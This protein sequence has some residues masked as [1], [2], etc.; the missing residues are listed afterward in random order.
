[1]EKITKYNESSLSKVSSSL[2]ADVSDIQCINVLLFDNKEIE[3]NQSV[4]EFPCLTEYMES[5]FG[6]ASDSK[7]KKLMAAATVMAKHSKAIESEK[8]SAY[9]TPISI[10]SVIDEGLNNM[11]SCY[12][13]ATGKLNTGQAIDI[14][15]DYAVARI[16]EA[17]DSYLPTIKDKAD[18]LVEKVVPKLVN[19][20][21]NALDSVIPQA[22]PVTEFIRQNIPFLT[23]KA[24]KLVSEG[25]DKVA[26]FAKT[27]VKNV[28]S[29]LKTM[30]ERILLALS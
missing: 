5:G 18:D 25:I 27:I 30:S 17:I 8:M 4:K 19:G 10:A 7:T 9:S 28:A 14:C 29:T 15:I 2:L 11:K 26:D 22:K 24:K 3:S 12:H 13:V 1:M 23:E 21:C 20:F 6:D 16:C